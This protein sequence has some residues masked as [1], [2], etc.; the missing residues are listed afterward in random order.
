[1]WSKCVSISGMSGYANVSE[2]FLNDEDLSIVQ[3]ECGVDNCRSIKWMTLPCTANATLTN[4]M[5]LLQRTQI[6]DHFSKVLSEWKLIFAGGML[7][8]NDYA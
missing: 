5:L 3:C 1:M 6:C 2:C 7:T 4:M 8:R